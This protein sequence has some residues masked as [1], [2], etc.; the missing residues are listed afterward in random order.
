MAIR[1]PLNWL[2]LDPPSM[3]RANREAACCSTPSAALTRG[4]LDALDAEHLVAEAV[5]STC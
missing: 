1:S 5:S 2:R 3:R 4:H